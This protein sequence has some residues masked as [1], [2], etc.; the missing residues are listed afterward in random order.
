MSIFESLL[1]FLPAGIANMA[2]LIA[3][4]LPY[5]NRWHTPMDFG[6]SF[7]GIRIFGA[8]KTWRGLVSATIA[9]TLVGALFHDK[10]FPDIEWSTYLLQCAAISAGALIGD[11][12]KSFFK[13]QR[14]VP[15]GSTWFPFDQI[16]FIIGALIF[17]LPFGWPPLSGILAIFLV[18]FG[19]HVVITFVSYHMGFKEKPI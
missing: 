8:N 2:P 12:A 3:N 14:G 17:M 15:P 6:H 7:R 1:L 9:G 4:K 10:F 18:Y 13:R 19:G 16:D 5:V 11:A